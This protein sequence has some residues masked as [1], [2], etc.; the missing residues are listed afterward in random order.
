MRSF[1]QHPAF[2]NAFHG[3]AAILVLVAAVVAVQRAWDILQPLVVAAVLATALWP[4]IARIEHVQLGPNHWHIPRVVAAASVFLITFSAAAIIITV[5]LAELLPALDRGLAAFPEQTGGISAYLQPFRIGD[6]A[7]G[8]GKIAGDVASQATGVQVDTRD[9]SA[10]FNVPRLG[11]ALFGGFLQLG[12]V[13][14]FT[15]FL[16]LEGERFGC[17]MLNLVPFE[18]RAHTHDLGIRIRNRVSRW[19]LAQVLYGSISGVI[20]GVTMSLLQLPSPWMYAIIGATLGIFPGLGPWIAMVPAFGVALGLSA[21]QATAVAVFGM[22][23]YVVD[24]TTLSSKIYGDM[25]H[26]PMFVVL[27]ALLIGASL[28]GVWG[29]MIAAPVAAGIQSIVEDQLASG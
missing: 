26:L 14:V 8:A 18:Q 19:V 11:V 3:G 5:S 20:I 4:W 27:I 15:F 1:V 28:M 29:A 25:L 7:A 9:Q 22:G 13:L 12:L 6:V 17:W 16:L 21:W 2:Q 24:S 23:M 10:P